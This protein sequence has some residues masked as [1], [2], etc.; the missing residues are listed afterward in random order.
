MSKW[1]ERS[2]ANLLPLSVSQDFNTA[3]REWRCSGEMK[4]HGEMS[5][6]LCSKKDLHYQFEIVNPELGN[7]LWVGSSCIQKFDIYVEDEQGQE[8]KT[9]KAAYLNKQFKTQHWKH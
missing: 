1:D 5:C 4:T 6:E 2:M 9:G 8:I 3:L 7:S